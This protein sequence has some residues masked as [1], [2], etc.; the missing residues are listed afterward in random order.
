MSVVTY[1]EEVRAEINRTKQQISTL[2]A[3]KKPGQIES[4]IP[5][6]KN[7]VINMI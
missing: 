5:T 7:N 1:E 3:M 2:R 6:L 4:G